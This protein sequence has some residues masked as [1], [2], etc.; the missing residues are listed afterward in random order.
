MMEPVSL[1]LSVVCGAF[2]APMLGGLIWMKA[3]QLALL[4]WVGGGFRFLLTGPVKLSAIL[5]LVNWGISASG[6][7][8]GLLVHAAFWGLPESPAEF[9]VIVA[10]AGISV[11]GF[12]HDML[13]FQLLGINETARD[14]LARNPWFRTVLDNP[15][16]RLV[17]YRTAFADNNVPR[18]FNMLVN[19]GMI[20]YGLGG[21]QLLATSSGERPSLWQSLRTSLTLNDLIGQ[22]NSP[23]T[24]PVWDAVALGSSFLVFFWLAMFVALTASSA[25]REHQAYETVNSG[26]LEPTADP[27]R[28]AA[29]AGV[30]GEG[31]PSA[32]V[33][34]LPGSGDVRVDPTRKLLRIVSVIRLTNRGGSIRLVNPAGEVVDHAV[35]SAG[36]AV[37]QGTPSRSEVRTVFLG[38]DAARLPTHPGATADDGSPGPRRV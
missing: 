11:L 37:A 27:V 15:E 22:S 29:A 30:R 2:L 38:Q 24:G 10:V 3:N 36:N 19:L 4:R 32:S 12:V 20:Y 35:Y 5:K 21:L 17:L 18:F 28:P 7:L 16:A 23:F 9:W 34:P 13:N 25:E 33:F 31:P 6:V 26:R 1:A 14:V 8:L